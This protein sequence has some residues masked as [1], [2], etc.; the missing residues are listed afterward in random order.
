M[1]CIKMTDEA[2]FRITFAERLTG[3]F[4]LSTTKQQFQKLFKVLTKQL[5][6]LF[7][8][9]EIIIKSKITNPIAMSLAIRSLNRFANAVLDRC[10]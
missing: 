10:Q 3:E 7:L 9:N 1:F 5:G 2:L 4:D 6:R 8:G